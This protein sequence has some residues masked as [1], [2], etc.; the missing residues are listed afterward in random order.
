MSRKIRR[1][2][3]MNFC[4]HK[5]ANT[6]EIKSANNPYKPERRAELI[7]T[8]LFL[9]HFLPLLVEQVV[10][11]VGNPN[12]VGVFSSVLILLL[13]KVAFSEELPLVKRSTEK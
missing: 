5:I 7:K 13:A 3:L 2:V 8:Q 1:R 11:R 12:L 6:K 10:G 9:L 4:L